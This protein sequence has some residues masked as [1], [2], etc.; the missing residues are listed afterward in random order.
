MNGLI[1]AITVVS[2]LVWMALSIAGNWMMFKKAG[3]PGWHS[4]V[5]FLNVY[6]EFSLCWKGAYGVFF[7]VAVTAINLIVHFVNPVSMVVKIIITVVTIILFIVH[8]KQCFRLA[9]S[10]G[11]GSLYGFFLVIFNGLAKII[12]GLSDAQYIGNPCEA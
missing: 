4:L 3:K 10:F 1:L 11:F 6:D 5:P 8:V 7:L 2:A 9:R 12:L